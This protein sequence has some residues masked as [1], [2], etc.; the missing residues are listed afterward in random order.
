MQVQLG[1]G[2]LACLLH[3]GKVVGAG[4][5][6]PSFKHV[7][8][9]TGEI[10]SNSKLLFGGERSARALLPITEGCVEDADVGSVGDGGRKVLR[11]IWRRVLAAP[12]EM[13]RASHLGPERGVPGDAGARRTRT[14]LSAPRARPL[15]DVSLWR[16]PG[17]DRFTGICAEGARAE[18]R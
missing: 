5:R 8:T 17:G 9:E 4:A 10:A 18:K 11:S 2:Q 7:D 3:G 12:I 16:D 14:P 15:H 1:D 6:E 13:L